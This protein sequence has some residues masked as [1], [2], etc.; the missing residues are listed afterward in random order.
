MW[1]RKVIERILNEKSNAEEEDG[2][3]SVGVEWDDDDPQEDEEMPTYEE[4]SIEAW[5]RFFF[6]SNE[7]IPTQSEIKEA[8]MMIG[9]AHQEASR[10]EDAIYFV[11]EKLYEDDEEEVPDYIIRIAKVCVMEYITGTLQIIQSQI[12]EAEEVED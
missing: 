5:K 11:A 4:V 8:E 1:I 3:S 12:D 6:D 2:E 7:R 10:L 9:Y